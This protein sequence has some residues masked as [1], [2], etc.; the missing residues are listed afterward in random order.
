[1]RDTSGWIEHFP[2]TYDAGPKQNE[3][4]HDKTCQAALAPTLASP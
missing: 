4:K 1:M 2:F 3:V